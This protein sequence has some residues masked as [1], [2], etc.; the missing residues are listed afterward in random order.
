IL[1]ITPDWK[2]IVDEKNLPDSIVIKIASLMNYVEIMG[3]MQEIDQATTSID[4]EQNDKMEQICKEVHNIECSFYEFVKQNNLYTRWTPKITS[5]RS[6]DESHQMNGFI[7]MD[8]IESDDFSICDNITFD[9][10]KQVL[11]ALVEYS[12][13]GEK[14]DENTSKKFRSKLYSKMMENMVHEDAKKMAVEGTRSFDSGSLSDIID[15]YEHVYMEAMTLDKIK[16]F[17]S[18]FANL[19]MKEVL[20][21]GDLWSTNLMWKRDENGHLQLKAIVDYQVGVNVSLLIKVKSHFS[22]PISTVLH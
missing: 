6:F 11:K 22:S 13:I 7:I 21:H 18:L 10:L 15:D 8:Y 12:T 1:L 5:L 14:I 16:Q 4:N 9:E 19:E 3:Q 2:N 17:D 20:I